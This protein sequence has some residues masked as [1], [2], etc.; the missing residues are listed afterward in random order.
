MPNLID[1]T[2]LVWE[3]HPSLVE[4]MGSLALV[5]DPLGDLFSG[6]EGAQGFS[7]LAWAPGS[8][9][10]ALT[11]VVGHLSCK[12]LV[13]LKDR[14]TTGGISEGLRSVFCGV[15]FAACWIFGLTVLCCVKLLWEVG[16]F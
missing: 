2:K 9:A 16:L 4:V 11:R 10:T 8:A 1:K 5:L 6:R 7:G 13:L 15:L 12:V 3:G 14:A